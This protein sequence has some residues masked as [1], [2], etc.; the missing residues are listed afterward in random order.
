MYIRIT[1]FV[2]VSKGEKKKIGFSV[3]VIICVLNRYFK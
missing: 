2:N 1:V 3:Y